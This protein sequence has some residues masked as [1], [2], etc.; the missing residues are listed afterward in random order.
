MGNRNAQLDVHQN[1]YE[2]EGVLYI[3]A[4]FEKYTTHAAAAMLY[5]NS[6]E[7]PEGFSPANIDI[8][9]SR[10]VLNYSLNKNANTLKECKAYFRQRLSEIYCY[11]NVELKTL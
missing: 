3:M 7:V 8:D 2:R 1:G 5:H 11:K 6:R 4:R 9:K 10:T